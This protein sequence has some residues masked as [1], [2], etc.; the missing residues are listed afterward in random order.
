MKSR[1]ATSPIQSLDRGLA[2]LEMV[3]Q[4][5]RPVSVAE[6][7]PMLEID[8]S[9]VF[10]LANTLRMRGFLIQL[11]SKE[12]VLG[13]AVCRLA[14]SFRWSHGLIQIAREQ[15]AALAARTGET[16][17]LVIRDGRQAVFVDH[18]ATAQPVGVSVGS[19]RTEPL[20]C[21]AVGKALIADMDRDELLELFGSQR[22]SATT[23]R[24]I[25]SI[26]ELVKECQRTLKRGYA[27]DN[28]EFHKGVRC[29]AAPI[30]DGSG[31]IVAAIGISAPVDRLSES[32]CEK[33]AQEVKRAA[34][35]IG[36]KLGSAVD[37]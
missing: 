1:K 35:E 29:I 5:R 20:H 2:I 33:V 37:A 27:I 26:T 25:R 32:R 19:G 9:S 12:Y 36:A 7:T 31:Q 4:A 21:T 6:L 8:R 11:P 16:T 3:G 30:R 24:A 13:S 28:E 10:R 23:K 22:L 15:V 18:E 34:A 17:H 14:G